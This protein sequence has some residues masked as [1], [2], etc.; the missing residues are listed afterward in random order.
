MSIT[1]PDLSSQGTRDPVLTFS[2]DEITSNTQK[3]GARRIPIEHLHRIWIGEKRFRQDL[4]WH[5]QAEVIFVTRDD[6]KSIYFQRVDIFK[7]E[8]KLEIKELVSRIGEIIEANEKAL[9]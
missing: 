7:P 6:D 9:L 8:E 3:Y 5:K 4:F 1:Q 2:R